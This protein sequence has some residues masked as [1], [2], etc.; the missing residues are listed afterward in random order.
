[1]DRATLES[2]GPVAIEGVGGGIVVGGVVNIPPGWKAQTNFKIGG[3]VR[4][5]IGRMCREDTC[6]SI[7]LRRGS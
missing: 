4:R 1:M 3:V 6:S 5:E 2:A 7:S